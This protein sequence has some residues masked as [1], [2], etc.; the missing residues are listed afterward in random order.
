LRLFILGE[1]GRALDARNVTDSGRHVIS[2]VRPVE[3]VEKLALRVHSDLAKEVREVVPHGARAQVHV[4]GDLAHAFASDQPG[5]DLQLPRCEVF[6]TR[7][8]GG[9]RK[10]TDGAHDSGVFDFSRDASQAMFELDHTLC[11]SPAGRR[12]SGRGQREPESLRLAVD[13]AE[14]ESQAL[15]GTGTVSH[16]HDDR[17]LSPVSRGLLERGENRCDVVGMHDIEKRNERY[18]SDA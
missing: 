16:A 14:R 4:P 2:S 13:R 9:V 5:S 10:P 6:E 18:S 11:G 7:Q 1:P 17:D 12:L 15:P 3:K 8:R